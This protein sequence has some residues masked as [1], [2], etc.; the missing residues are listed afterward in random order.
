MPASPSWGMD[1]GGMAV[2]ANEGMIIRPSI[3]ASF[4]ALLSTTDAMESLG[5]NEGS[6]PSS[7]FKRVT[8]SKMLDTAWVRSAIEVLR[9]SRLVLTS[10]NP[11]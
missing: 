8:R 7:F 2:A 9:L 1:E 5:F 3:A 4:C 10:T 11:F 6:M